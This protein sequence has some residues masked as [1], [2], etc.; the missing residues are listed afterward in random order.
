MAITPERINQIEGEAGLFDFLREELGWNLPD[1]PDFFDFYPDEL[2]LPRDTGEYVGRI[3][4]LANFEEGQPWGIFLVKFQGD[5]VYRSALRK[6][7]RGL[8]DTRKN[9]PANLPAWSAPNLL[10]ICTPTFKDFTFARFEGKSHTKATLSLFGWEKGDSALHTLCQHNLRALKYPENPSD[11]PKWLKDW[12]EA[13]DVEAVT[14]RFFKEYQTIFKWA[15]DTIEQENPA[16]KTDWNLFTQRLFNRLMFIQF[17]SKKGWLT[18]EGS[19]DYL[20]L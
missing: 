12:A 8:S 17:L 9:R 18:F 11:V 13:F 1:E 6:I 14:E 5:R 10:F 2:G 7:L 19:K 16:L 3:T 4:Q 15:L 20:P